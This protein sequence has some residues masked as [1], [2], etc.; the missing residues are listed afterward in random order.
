MRRYD[1]DQPSNNLHLFV[2]FIADAPAHDVDSCIAYDELERVLNQSAKPPT[3]L[4][5]LLDSH[6]EGASY[7]HVER[8]VV[9]LNR[10]YGIPLK[11]IMHWTGSHPTGAEPINSLQNLCAFSMV[12]NIT[13][14]SPMIVPTHHF[15]MLGRI[16]RKHRVDAAVSILRRNLDGFGRM[17]CGCVGDDGCTFDAAMIP[18]E[19]SGMFPMVID[20]YVGY[21]QGNVHADDTLAIPDVTGAFCHVIGES[22]HESQAN[23]WTL[24][25]PTEKT[26]KCFLLGQVPLF[27]GPM[28]LA[29]NIREFGFDLF[30][31]VIN[32][33]YDSV[34]DPGKRLEMIMD[35][36]ESICSQPIEKLSAYKL[37]NLQRFECNR[38]LC[39]ILRSGLEDMH[40][41]RFRSCMDAISSVKP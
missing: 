37:D 25:F 38:N 22:S 7:E 29:A 6:T 36:L 15:V 10:D 21:G 27:N 4:V 17:S 23:G 14:L 3:R 39:F 1:K 18:D 35:Q 8:T 9:R 30:D 20:G 16:P 2:N 12:S 32:H 24:P 34:P 26:E 33:S 28:H 31:D 41:E 19:F 5:I 13:R 11:H 40:Y